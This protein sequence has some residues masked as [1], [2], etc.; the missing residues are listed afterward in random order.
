V[1]RSN[2]FTLLEVMVAVSVT[3]VLVIL[4]LRIFTEGSTAWQ[5]NDE[6]LDTFRE[7]RAALQTM[8]RDFSA[9]SPLPRA[10]PTTTP[11]PGPGQPSQP[12][13]LSDFPLLYI[14]HYPETEDVDKVNQEIYGL[15]PTRNKGRSSLCAVGYY[16]VWDVNKHAFILR[17]QCTESNTTFNALKAVLSTIR[18]MNTTQAVETLFARGLDPDV[19]SIDDLATYIWDFQVKIA[20]KPADPVT[21]T[22]A[23]PWPD[24]Q[25][26][27]SRELPL[28]VEIRFKALGS[29]AARKIENQALLNRDVWFDPTSDQYQKLILPGEQEFVTRIK[30]CR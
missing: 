18:P 10:E 17:R 28:W 14:D 29:N 3:L 7:A 12:N 1:K 9:L 5:R 4:M 25:K 20:D 11:A 24:T 22:G 26:A 13:P 21:G 16:C 30:L 27:F 23:Q 6:K 19:Q 15:I 8:A 2:A